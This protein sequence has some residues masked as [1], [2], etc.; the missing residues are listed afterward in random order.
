MKKKIILLT[1]FLISFIIFT[2]NVEAAESLTCIYEKVSCTSDAGSMSYTHKFQKKITQDSDGNI[3]FYSLKPESSSPSDG[4]RNELFNEVKPSSISYKNTKAYDKSSKTLTKCPPCVEYTGGK[5]C[6][7][8]VNNNFI[9]SDY[10]DAKKKECPSKYEK[11]VEQTKYESENE[12]GCISITKEEA[13]K[14]IKNTE[15]KH[16]CIYSNS[17][18]TAGATIYFNQSKYTV[19]GLTIDTVHSCIKLS[20]LNKINNGECPKEIYTSYSGDKVFLD[21]NNGTQIH[22]MFLLSDDAKPKEEEPDVNINSCSDLFDKDLIKEI[23]KVMDVIKIA[24]PIL[25]LVFGIA[26]FL[27]ATFDNS[28]DEMKKNRDRFIKRIIAAVIVFLV[29]TFVNL[30]LKLGNTVWSDINPNTCINNTE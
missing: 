20:E 10:K 5:S 13:E 4:G 14:D 9:F 11:L 18:G 2:D 27:K 25:L 6:A 22:Q 16:I 3:K 17:E 24:V 12:A 1:T 29:P 8:K 19:T 21:S 7:N 23:N 26:D 30:I 28:E 15:Y